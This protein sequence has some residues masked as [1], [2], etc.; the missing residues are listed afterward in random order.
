M[1]EA[2]QKAIARTEGTTVDALKSDED[3]IFVLVH[4]LEI[5]GEA[6]RGVSAETKQA[7]PQIPWAEMTATRDRLIHGYF[8]VDVEIVWQIVRHDLPRVVQQLEEM[9]PA[10]EP[11]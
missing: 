4:L 2:A 3:R 5:L 9:V 7:H 8:S 11:E 1:L 10:D 6:A